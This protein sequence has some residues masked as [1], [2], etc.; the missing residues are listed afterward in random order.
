MNVE[1]G[2][3]D[4]EETPKTP[5]ELRGLIE[6]YKD[7][8]PPGSRIQIA[9]RSGEIVEKI[10]MRYEQSSIYALTKVHFKNVK[11]KGNTAMHIGILRTAKLLERDADPI[12][13]ITAEYEDRVRSVVHEFL[14]QKSS[15]AVIDIAGDGS[16][17]VSEIMIVMRRKKKELIP[18]ATRNASDEDIIADAEEIL[19]NRRT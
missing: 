13:A 14:K 6:S 11:G 4:F 9:D 1:S 3:D 2:P 15:T 16:Y 8:F 5:E 10:V 18:E 12:I 17:V 7:R 19:R